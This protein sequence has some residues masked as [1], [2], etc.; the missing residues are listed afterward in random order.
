MIGWLA[1]LPRATE[2]VPREPWLPLGRCSRGSS[3]SDS[4]H[5]SFA[6]PLSPIPMPPCAIVS[7]VELG[8]P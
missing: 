1:P 5:L 7:R 3:R 6:I 4:R 8:L 2:C